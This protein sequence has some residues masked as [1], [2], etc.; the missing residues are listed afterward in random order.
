[1]NTAYSIFNTN[2]NLTAKGNVYKNSDKCYTTKDTENGTV[3]GAPRGT[4]RAA[5]N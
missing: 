3:A 1:M 5:V 2:I 4:T